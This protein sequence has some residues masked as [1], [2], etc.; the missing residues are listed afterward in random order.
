MALDFGI[1]CDTRQMRA[2][3]RRTLLMCPEVMLAGFLGS[4]EWDVAYS[5]E[6]CLG[7]S[8]WLADAHAC[9]TRD[10]DG[11]MVFCL[12]NLLVLDFVGEPAL[13]EKHFRA[14]RRSNTLVQDVMFV[15]SQLWAAGAPFAAVLPNWDDAAMAAF[16]RLPG[17]GW[18]GG[19]QC[20][21]LHSTPK[22]ILPER[23]FATL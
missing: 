14:T 8:A 16:K 23:L 15:V 4:A 9:A 17:M 6:N 21:L 13:R 22:D 20:T 3:D 19:L 7:S 12:S 11:L 18:T 5:V 1:D 10:C 2:W